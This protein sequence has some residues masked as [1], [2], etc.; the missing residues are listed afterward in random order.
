MLGH[1]SLFITLSCTDYVFP[2][3]SI[4]DY[5]LYKM[6]IISVCLCAGLWFIA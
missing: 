4:Y 3:I 2:I 6:L 5:F 1:L